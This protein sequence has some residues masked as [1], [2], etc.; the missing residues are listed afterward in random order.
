MVGWSWAGPGKGRWMWS[1]VVGLTYRDMAN[2]DHRNSKRKTE[3]QLKL[4]DGGMVKRVFVFNAIVVVV[5][6][7]A[8][9]VL[10]KFLVK[11]HSIFFSIS[12]SM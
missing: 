9:I 12:S 5:E 11:A 2:G 6:I 10:F 3:H 8:F 7:V 4:R 1:R